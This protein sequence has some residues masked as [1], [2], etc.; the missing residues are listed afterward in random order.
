MNNPNSLTSEENYLKSYAFSTENRYEFI[1]GEV[2]AMA[3]VSA[4]HIRIATNITRA[5]LNHFDKH[6]HGDC[7]AFMSD[8]KV[9]TSDKNYYYPDVVID[10]SPDSEYF[11]E[12]PVIIVE[13]LSKATRKL[14]LTDKLAD[15]KKI[16]SLQAYVLVEQYDKEI[17]LYR[18]SNDWQLESYFAGDTIVFETFNFT[19]SVDD[20][21]AR[22]LFAT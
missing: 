18:R 17:R 5:F 11:A 6:K 22:V 16:D 20:I 8:I 14:D 21:Y 7:D 19:L 15:Y 1:H 9:K 10:C 3:G 12:K 2:R 4:N 13:V